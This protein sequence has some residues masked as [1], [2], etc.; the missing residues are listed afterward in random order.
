MTHDQ[1]EAMTLGDRVAVMRA[2]ILQQ[3][4]TPKELY[5]NPKNLF[6]AGFI[7]SPAMN[8]MPARIEGGTVHLPFGQARCPTSCAAA[9]SP[10]TASARDV[11]AGVRP[12]HFEDAHVA[13][14]HAG[15][16]F[17]TKVDVLESMGSELYAYFHVEGQTQSQ[18]LAELAEDAGMSDLP[19]RRGRLAG[20]RAA[21][22][23]VVGRAGRRG[24][25][26]A[27]HSKIQLFDVDGANSSY[28]NLTAR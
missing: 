19:G 28:A 23:G 17:R 1:T 20:R 5:E 2:G 11:I 25:A 24:R 13:G 18:E 26:R 16:R 4:D 10:A 27:R 9:S 3:V 8:F 21:L 7:G 15:L 14:D 6:V 12:E 22:A